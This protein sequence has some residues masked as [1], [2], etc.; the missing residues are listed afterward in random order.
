[1]VAA[2]DAKWLLELTYSK[3]GPARFLGHLDVMRHTER[4]I[5][6]ARLPVAMSEGFNPR[7]KL[8]FAAPLGVGA[9]SDC[10]RLCVTLNEPMDPRVLLER[11]APHTA[12][13]LAV[14][15]AV[16]LPGMKAPP[17]HLIPWAEWEI[18]LPPEPPDLGELG[19][20]CA[21][22]LGQA[23]V[24]VTRKTKKRTDVV[25]IRPAVKRLEAAGAACFACRL[26]LNDAPT[27]KPLE[28]VEALG[29]PRGD[30][31]MPHPLVRRTAL[32]PTPE[33]E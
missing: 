15:G 14:T 9:T 19:A 10:E 30:S 24:A 25:D 33:A 12:P 23:H 26:S 20:R 29:Y 2:P 13:G 16:A 5:R 28:V 8:V 32:A 7:P 22:F 27:A 17:Y 3:D 4:A 11:L 21:R 18:A 6:R 31:A 1:M